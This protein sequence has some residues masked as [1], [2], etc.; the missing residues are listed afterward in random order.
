MTNPPATPRG[1]PPLIGEAPHTLVLGSFPS[2]ASL[3]AQQYYAHPRNAFWPIMGALLGFDATLPYPERTR[4]L[5]ACGIALWDVVATCHRPGSRDEAIVTSSIV[6]NDIAGLLA[7]TPTI[8]RIVTNGATAEKL[9]RRYVWRTLPPTMR[10]RLLLHSAPSTSPA[11]A[12]RTVA[13]K[14]ALW[15]IVLGLP[16]PR[17]VE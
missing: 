1:F 12:T 3:A 9:F 17:G 10:S 16:A 5:T 11:H 2:V 14:T 4:A 8:T 7:A 15:R 13:E 6:P